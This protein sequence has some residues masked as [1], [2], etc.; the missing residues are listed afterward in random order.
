MESMRRYRAVVEL[1]VEV[2]VM[3]DPCEEWQAE[4]EIKKEAIQEA[5]E[6]CIDNLIS[7]EIKETECYD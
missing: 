7:I 4:S 1:L 3:T 6:C 2:E 5:A